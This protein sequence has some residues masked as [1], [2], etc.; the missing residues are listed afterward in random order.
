M[1]FVNLLLIQHIRYIIDGILMFGLLGI[2]EIEAIFTFFIYY[3]FE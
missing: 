2:E 1:L 3:L